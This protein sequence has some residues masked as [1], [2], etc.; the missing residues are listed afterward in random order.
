VVGVQRRKLIE[1][2]LPLEA[3]NAE[4]AREKS[5]RHGHPS[6]LHLWWARRPLAAARAVLFAQLVDDP[7]ARPE[8]FPSEED[9]AVERKR[10]HRLME[11]LVKWENSTN[12]EV[13][14]AARAEILKSTGGAPPPILDPFCGGGTIP[15]EAQRLGLEAHASD[16]NPVAVL[17]TKALIEIPPK[18]RDWKPVFP[19]LA[20]SEYRPWAGAA[21]LAADVRAYGQWMRDEAE[22]RIGHLYPKA[23][24]PDGTRANVI[25]WIWA[26]TVTCPNPGC[27]IEM[28]LTGKWWLGKKKGKEAYVVPT[29][30]DDPAARG[31]RR[32]KFG[33]GH[34]PA[35]APTPETD[36]TMSGRRGA[37]C[38]ACGSSANIDYIK[39]EGMAGRLGADLMAVVAEGK[40]TRIYLEPTT[41]HEKAASVDR[42][43]DVPDQ[44]MATNPRWFSPPSFG[45]A[46]FSDL[47]TNR[48]L[49]AL[50]TFS[51]LVTEARERVYKDAL[52]AGIPDGERLDAGGTGASTYADAVAT[53]LGMAVSRYANFMNALCQW[54]PDAGKE[55][56]GHLFARQAIPM[57]WDYAESHP[58]S[59]AAGSWDQN[60]LFIP[61][62]LERISPASSGTVSSSNA[63]TR[64]Y[65][66]MLVATDPPYYDNIGYSDLSDFFYVWLRRCLRD[67]HPYTLSTVLVPKADELVANPY[68][69]GGRDDASR[70]FEDGFARVFRLAREAAIQDY[71][72]TVFYAF[73]QVEKTKEGEV[74]T[75]WETLLEGMVRSGWAITGTWP[76]R[77]ELSNRMLAKDTNALA[78]SIVLAL[79]PRPD[80]APQI[81]RRGF[82]ARL[83]SELPAKLKELQQGKIA[84]VDLPQA[85]IGPGMAMFTRYSGVIESDGSK[86]R[87]R[88]ALERIN[89]VLDEVLAEQEGDFVADTRFAIAWYRQHGY[90]IGKFG[91]ADNMARARNTSVEGLKRSGI[92]TS[93]AGKVA[94]IRPSDLPAGYD[95][96]TD[97]RITTW[98][99]VHHL[100]RILESDGLDAAGRFLARVEAR[101]DRAVRLHLSKELAFLLFSIADDRKWSQDA[102][103]FNTLGTAWNDIVETSR[104]AATQ[105]EQ[106]D[107]AEGWG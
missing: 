8:E 4:S 36:G 58:W 90:G 23:T 78:S 102:I 27:G 103:A 100:I 13:L 19:G 21:G 68:R 26:R 50:T 10:L 14:A 65:G 76:M 1:V 32:V 85:A 12:E 57:V 6:T 30:V 53:F 104:A 33:I 73:K 69:H 66:G 105:Y 72:T 37:V 63:S 40:R 20:D 79:R 67:V 38:V 49:V 48:Q 77:S 62:A 71:P 44:E 45:L 5:I 74:S 64:S 47:F 28:P 18:F 75:G 80:G 101:P 42:P 9:Q 31:G 89:E 59:N 52:T 83:K 88:S 106:A 99:V 84:P 96:L 34:D 70:F 97:E 86:M 92:L 81:D 15:L 82:I 94:L 17:I 107:L 46:T 93:R 95:P 24:L 11:E 98:E 60:L 2:A 56:V 91:D 54:R 51:E 87:V 61:K 55:Q 7:S 16:L 22:K 41:E 35:K 25:A 43:V 3:I 39:G 29:V